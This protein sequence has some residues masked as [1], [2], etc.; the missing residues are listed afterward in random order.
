ML[1]G[2][3]TLATMAGGALAQGISSDPA[4]PSGPAGSESMTKSQRV[5]H[6]DGSVT[7]RTQSYDKSQNY[8][9][10]DGELSAHSMVR[11][12]EQTTVVPP[13]P[14]PMTTTTTTT[15]TEEIR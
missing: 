11:T 4:F 3:F 14:P 5:I 2:V 15:H 10:G 13:P 1:A 9:S 7:E 12:N 8:T 6:S